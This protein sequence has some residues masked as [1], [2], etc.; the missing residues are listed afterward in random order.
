M[1][2]TLTLGKVYL[3]PEFV[4]ILHNRSGSDDV[5]RAERD[6]E[7][8]IREGVKLATNCSTFL[9]RELR[10][11]VPTVE[12]PCPGFLGRKVRKVLKDATWEERIYSSGLRSIRLSKVVEDSPGLSSDLYRLASEWPDLA[13]EFKGAINDELKRREIP[14]IRASRF[15]TEVY[16]PAPVEDM[17]LDLVKE[18]ISPLKLKMRK[19]DV[20][21]HR[22]YDTIFS[23]VDGV[24]VMM[25]LGRSRQV[26]KKVRKRVR[27][28]LR[29]G[30]DLVLAQKVFYTSSSLWFHG[31]WSLI[32][33]LMIL[34][35]E[36]LRNVTGWRDATFGS[37]YSH[38]LRNFDVERRFRRYIEGFWLPTLDLKKAVRISVNL[39][40][41][42]ASQP[43]VDD[44]LV[45]LEERE[46]AILQAL[47]AK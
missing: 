26:N 16:F 47:A 11:S 4:P 30:I 37:T 24:L 13:G 1:R 29:M 9:G 22:L 12:N 15:F 28:M 39:F 21:E 2:V 44:V 20:L 6:E 46:C 40:R 8:V 45:T 18:L 34:N 25:S 35:P 23:S 17:P 7:Y 31:E 14:N 5:R 41:L 38:L 19:P 10:G 36:V 33:G 42:G 27:G 43:N 3:E 32:N